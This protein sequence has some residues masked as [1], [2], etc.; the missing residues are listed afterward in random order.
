[1]ATAG[2]VVEFDPR[3][4]FEIARRAVE[5]RSFCVLATTSAAN[6]PHAVGILYAPV[7]L[8]LYLLMSEDAIK[9]RNVRANPNVAISIPVRKYPMGPPMAVQFQGTAEILG[10]DDPHVVRLRD[11]GRL[12]KIMPAGM[13]TAAQAQGV[14]VM[15]VVPGRRISTYGLG[16]PLRRILRDPA[17]GQRSVPVPHD[18]A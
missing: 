14:C 2:N 11:A 6:K 16:V 4:Q 12:K 7:G 9:V 15:K 5:K 8:T 13:K 1:M 10:M 17:C 18:P 3:K